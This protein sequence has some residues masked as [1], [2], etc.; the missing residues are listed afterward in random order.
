MEGWVESKGKANLPI[1]S[2]VHG[3][4]VCRRFQVQRSLVEGRR[5]HY[6]HGAIDRRCA[7]MGVFAQSTEYECREAAG[8]VS[9]QQRKGARGSVAWAGGGWDRTGQDR[10]RWAARA[11]AR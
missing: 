4:G 5:C 2:S 11:Q 7:L 9:Q 8:R 1:G 6:S 3:H 10:T